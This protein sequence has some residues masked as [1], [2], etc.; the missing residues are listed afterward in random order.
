MNLPWS[1]ND[2]T[3]TWSQNEDDNR[4]VGR[5][6]TDVVIL[7]SVILPPR[8]EGWQKLWPGRARTR[9]QCMATVYLRREPDGSPNITILDRSPVRALRQALEAVNRHEKQLVRQEIHTIEMEEEI[10]EALLREN[11]L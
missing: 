5:R 11:Q 6:G 3:F 8:R 7:E 2:E 9:C 1:K 4:W 10:L